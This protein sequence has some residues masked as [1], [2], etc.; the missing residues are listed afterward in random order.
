MG[1]Q[2]FFLFLIP[3]VNQKAWIAKLEMASCFKFIFLLV[4]CVL[5]RP[6]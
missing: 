6:S 1:F 4:N 3:T 2:K 5:S